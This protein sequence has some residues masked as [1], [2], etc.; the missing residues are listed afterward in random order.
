[1]KLF[2]LF[3]VCFHSF[4]NFLFVIFRYNLLRKKFPATSFTGS[5]VLSDAG[6]DLL[7]R[8]L[9]YDPE[10]VSHF[11]QLRFDLNLKFPQFKNFMVY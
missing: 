4:S 5:G 11:P 6:F 2:A 3:F 1:M 9:A 8:L 7:S 10:Q